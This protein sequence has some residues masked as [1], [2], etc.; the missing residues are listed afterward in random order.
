MTTT[1]IPTEYVDGKTVVATYWPGP[2]EPKYARSWS[3]LE[4][5]LRAIGVSYE[6]TTDGEGRPTLVIRCASGRGVGRSAY[7]HNLVCDHG[8][9]AV[10]R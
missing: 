8:G 4:E 6:P 7:I 5:K 10:I 1:M 3:R 9:L 2:D